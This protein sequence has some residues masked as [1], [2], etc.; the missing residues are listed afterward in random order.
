MKRSIPLPGSRCRT[1]R[2]TRPRAPRRQGG[3][4]CRQAPRP[5][6]VRRPPVRK[7]VSERRPVAASACGPAWLASG[8]C[9]AGMG[10]G[11]SF[12]AS[13]R[14]VAV[15]GLAARM[16]VAVLGSRAVLPAAP[17]AADMR[18]DARAF[19]DVLP[20]S[21]RRTGPRRAGA[22]DEEV[23]VRAA[24]GQLLPRRADHDLG[25]DVDVG[26]AATPASSRSSCRRAA[27]S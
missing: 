20:R 5:L 26:L 11:A 12:G 6:R 4:A 15:A 13:R 17:P 24:R 2:A 14:G 19:V 10:S 3:A 27:S 23:E 18:R 1:L 22:H 9:D 25:R 21:S 16:R 8:C 7:L